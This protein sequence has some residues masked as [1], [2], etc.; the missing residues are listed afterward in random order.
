MTDL[1]QLWRRKTDN[2]LHAAAAR[3]HEY[4]EASQEA[5]KAEIER[6]KGAEYL[7][8][9]PPAGNGARVQQPQRRLEAPPG[10]VNSSAWVAQR[11]LLALALMIGFYILAITIAAAL[12]WIPYAEMA[13]MNRLDARIAIACV[14]SALAIL[15]SLV[16]QRDRFTPPGPQLHESTS[17]RLF[18]LIR[19]VAAGTQQEMPAD[20][21]LV[22]DVNA[23]VTQRGGVMGFGSRRVMGIGLPLLQSV[24]VPELEAIIA[25]EFGHYSSGDVALGP[26]IYKTRAAVMR[27]ITNLRAGPVRA[28]F[29]W[30]ARQFLT[31]THAVSR[32]QEYI[33][34]Q[35]AA[36]VAGPDTMASALRR[37]AVAAPLYSAYL[38]QEVSP[39]L[40]A[41]LIP[42]I[43]A[44]FTEF[45]AADRIGTTA[46]QILQASQSAA[47]T[48]VFDTHPSLAER[49]AALGVTVST[50]GLADIGEPAAALLANH[51][52]YAR[53]LVAVTVGDE[54]FRK[55]TP[56]DW[57]AVGAAVYPPE[58]RLMVR[59]FAPFLSR[60][61]ADTLP[62]S[63][64]AFIRAGSDL[65]REGEMNVTMDQRVARAAQV[66][67]VAVNLLLLDE[68]WQVSTG[69][70]RPIVLVHGSDTFEPFSAIQALAAG[71]FGAADW[72]V[73]CSA[74]GI[75]GR[76]LAGAA[77]LEPSSKTA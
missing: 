60:Y 37:V 30:Y 26:W 55:L 61:T 77:T 76:P 73:R 22:S 34:D 66:F 27:T 14:G 71:T 38:N 49:L 1:E 13:Y 53:A 5:V 44:G 25:H 2:E 64:D 48:N 42:P 16:P 28:P 39:A 8:S 59:H 74:L 6:R 24:S 62:D 19:R 69:P 68:G 15:W 20:V 7:R 31:L 11:A 47:Q 35:V 58:W 43:A 40:T 12:L 36:R 10:N 33:A 72:R 41:G 32:R 67:A 46:R 56:I 17:P 51:E 70:G 23:F 52:Q 75:A 3:L 21:Y 65:V 4:S 45:M 18:S 9:L 63:R 54:Q 57:S 29:L 50:D